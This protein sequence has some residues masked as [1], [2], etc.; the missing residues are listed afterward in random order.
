[1]EKVPPPPG[2]KIVDATGKVIIAGPDIAKILPKPPELPG[3]PEVAPKEKE[4]LGEDEILGLEP[5]KLEAEILEGTE[6]G[7]EVPPSDK[8]V[9]GDELTLESMEIEEVET[10]IG[11]AELTGEDLVI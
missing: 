6:G 11:E 1:M 9:S 3:L 7:I 2:V 8:E 10:G 4:K 5:T